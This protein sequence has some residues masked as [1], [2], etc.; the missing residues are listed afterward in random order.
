MGVP[1]SAWVMR[2]EEHGTWGSRTWA[3]LLSLPLMGC[4]VLGQLSVFP[5]VQWNDAP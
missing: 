1:S 5:P 4:V 2:E 3:Q